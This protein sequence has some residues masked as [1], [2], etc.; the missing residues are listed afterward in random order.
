MTNERTKKFERRRVVNMTKIFDFMDE[1]DEHVGKPTKRKA[2][3][4][5]EGN[6]IFKRRK[7]ID[8]AKLINFTDDE[9]E[10]NIP[11]PSV[12]KPGSTKKKIIFLD[13]EL[14]GPLPIQLTRLSL[15]LPTRKL[16]MIRRLLRL[17]RLLHHPKC[18][19]PAML[20]DLGAR[21]VYSAKF[22][23][24]RGNV[25]WEKLRKGLRKVFSKDFKCSCVLRFGTIRL[26]LTDIVV[27]AK[28]LSVEHVQKF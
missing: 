18:Q 5:N 7:V 12:K 26:N 3:S 1:E 19:E 23:D 17:R 9:D 6:E 28:C 20:V 16:K 8:P 13:T 24:K 25:T 4:S 10:E 2:V 22:K 11:L 15:I 21:I 14:R 27:Y